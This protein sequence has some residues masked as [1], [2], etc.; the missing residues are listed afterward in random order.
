M[1]NAT[2]KIIALILDMPIIIKVAPFGGDPNDK[3]LYIRKIAIKSKIECIIEDIAA[4][5]KILPSR[6]SF[7]DAIRNINTPKVKIAIKNDGVYI[8][9]SI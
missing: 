9:K 6:A 4:N 8:K 1:L 7:F 3:E 2:R 5:N